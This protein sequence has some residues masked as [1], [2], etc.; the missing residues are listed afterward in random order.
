[1]QMTEDL[2]RSVVQQVLTQMGSVAAPVT[3]GQAGLGEPRR[4]PHGGP[5]VAAADAAF[6]AF[7]TR[8]LGDRAKAVDCIRK[9]CVDQA[10]ELGRMEL[11]E[12]RSAGSTT[13]SPSSGTRSLGCPGRGPSDR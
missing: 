1:M 4:L 2:I 5:A 11:E 6:Q 10:E 12:T 13:R 7:R 9:I 3:N 8:P